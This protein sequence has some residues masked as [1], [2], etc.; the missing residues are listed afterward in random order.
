MADDKLEPLPNFSYPTG[1]VIGNFSASAMEVDAGDVLLY[2]R[3]HPFALMH[4]ANGAK[5]AYGQLMWRVDV[6]D[7]Y[8]TTA[9]EGS[10]GGVEP[11]DSAGQDVIDGVNA[12]IPTLNDHN[13][14]AMDPTIPNGY[15]E[16]DGYGDVY[17]VWHLEFGE[18]EILTECWV[19]VGTVTTVVDATAVPNAA[20]TFNRFNGVGTATGQQS[21]FYRIKLGTVTEGALVTQDVSSDVH[22]SFFLIERELTA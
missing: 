9:S 22:W 7:F 10:G 19:E 16:L 12:V 11:M 17:L 13:G 18:S 6:I 21:G 20:T 1:S 8:F 2:H 14:D 3:P 4:G 5:I 15:H